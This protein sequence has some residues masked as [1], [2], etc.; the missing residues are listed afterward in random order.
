[1]GK[2][3]GQM[4][5]YI[6]DTSKKTQSMVE[7]FSQSHAVKFTMAILKMGFVKEMD[8]EFGQMVKF[9]KE[10]GKIM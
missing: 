6:W 4:E 9:M 7:A 3:F 10:L 5:L 1:M 2:N 8:G